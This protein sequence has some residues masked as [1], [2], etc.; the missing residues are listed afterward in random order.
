MLKFS[1]GAAILCL[2]APMC[3][4]TSSLRA[5]QFPADHMVVFGDSLSDNG[6]LYT[7]I[8]L[9]VP[10]TYDLG[11]STDGA[12]TY[13]ASSISGLWEEQ[14]APS[15]GLAVPQPDLV[16][17]VNLNFSFSGAETGAI[18]N[19]TSGPYGMNAQVQQYLDRKPANIAT[20]L[21]FFWGGTNDVFDYTDPLSAEK[22]AIANI[23]S[24]IG[25]VAQAG[26]RYFVWLNLF[27]LDLTPRGAGS[28]SIKA[29]CADFAADMP[30]AIAT[31]QASFPG[32]TIIPV[33]LYSFFK[34]MVQSPAGYA[35]ANVTTESQGFPVNPDQYI[36]WDYLHPTTR[37]HQLIAGLVLSDV[38]RVLG[39]PS[40]QVRHPVSDEF[41]AG[42][43]DAN[44][45]TVEAP[46]DATVS[47]AG[48]HAVL[49][50]PGGAN[51]D[52]FLGGNQSARILQP[53]SNTDFDVAAKF[54]SV[55]AAAFAGQGILVQQDNG[56]YLRFEVASTGAQLSVS[57][58]SVGGGNETNSFSVPLTG[59]ESSIWLEVKRIGDIWTLNTSTDGVTYT[60]AGTF[61]QPISV[62]AIGPYAWNYN[63]DVSASPAMTSQVDFF[64]NTAQ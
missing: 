18:A 58:A 7:V 30:Q 10:P 34:Q 29:A 2:F 37:V 11:R 63:G 19:S 62:S 47:V 13:P 35:F 38:T 55:P 4:C 27:P 26:G 50:L 39:T 15:L 24:Q 31:L 14:L 23:S 40:A 33:D 46:P 51:H 32:I 53:I 16:N 8:H 5:D 36:F 48:G 61:D 28:E 49:S 1:S 45:W 59:S 22:T 12:T 60:T 17:T 57:G 20:A 52:P 25:S 43:L 44:V 42:L 21:H 41:A 6:N 54:D 9:P 3:F 56:T 64:H